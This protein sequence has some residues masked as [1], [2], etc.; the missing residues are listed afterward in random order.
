MKIAEINFKKCGPLTF[1]RENSK[2]SLKVSKK[3][4]EIEGFLES[5]TKKFKKKSQKTGNSA[6]IQN[7]MGF[8]YFS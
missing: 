4:T 2:F 5:F 6:K 8:P 1:I 7:F 3:K